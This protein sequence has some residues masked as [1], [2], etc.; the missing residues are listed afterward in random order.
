[1]IAQS[2]FNDLVLPA[3]ANVLNTIHPLAFKTEKQISDSIAG[4]NIGQ[5]AEYIKENDIP[6]NAEIA[7][8]NTDAITLQWYE[9]VKTT[10]KDKEEHIK[11]N[12]NNY[13]YSAVFT[14]LVKHEYTRIGVAS[15]NFKQYRDTTVYDMYTKGEHDRLKAYYSLF[16][17]K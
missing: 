2:D 15:Y 13:A 10:D 14:I 5:L 17:K 16:F 7:Y 11:R 4:M 1:M 3:L 6:S 9:L 8:S 12:F